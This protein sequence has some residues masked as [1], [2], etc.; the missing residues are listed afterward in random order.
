MKK[1]T[2]IKL[3]HIKNGIDIVHNTSEQNKEVLFGFNDQNNFIQGLTYP[4][5]MYFDMDV[6]NKNNREIINIK[7]KSFLYYSFNY[8]ISFAHYMTQC[9]PKLKTF[10]ENDDMLLV[11]PESTYNETCKDILNILNIN[12]NKILIVK[13][14]VEYR[15]D[16]LYVVEHI[17]DQWGGPGNINEDGVKVCELI[18]KN[19]NIFPT[20]KPYRKVYLKRDGAPNTTH[21]NGEVGITRKILNEEK[22]ID[23]L[24]NNEFEIIELG[25]KSIND[26][27]EALKDIKILITQLGANCMNL[28]FSNNIENSIFLSNDRPIAEAFYINMFNRLSNNKNNH[29]NLYYKSEDINADP[30]NGWNSPFI[31]NVND[32]KNILDQIQ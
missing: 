27:K 14:D 17:G 6:L 25:S 5:N 10:I 11:I 12:I 1:Y 7:N 15:F 20:N 16:E 32:I 8:Q 18:R 21:G 9:L 19:L 28:I 2:N 26:K 3:V 29:H 30:K 22:L 23:F 13:D 31:V 4:T 24:K